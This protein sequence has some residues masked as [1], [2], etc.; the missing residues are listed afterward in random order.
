MHA[1][2][3]AAPLALAFTSAACLLAACASSRPAPPKAPAEAAEEPTSPGDQFGF[4]G[5][6]VIARMR[7]AKVSGSTVWLGH[8]TRTL[9]PVH[10][11]IVTSLL[12]AATGAPGAG[13]VDDELP[14]GDPLLALDGLAVNVLDESFEVMCEGRLSRP[15]LRYAGFVSSDDGPDLPAALL[16]GGAPTLLATL[17]APCSGAYVSGG[18]ATAIRAAD[19]RS[20]AIPEAA[21]E[22]LK[23]WE[24]DAQ[25]GSITQLVAG[26]SGFV[27]VQVDTPDRCDRSEDHHWY[28]HRATRGPTGWTFEPLAD[29]NGSD[30]FDRVVDV[31]GDGVLDALTQ[32]GAFAGKGYQEWEPDLRLFWP[33]GLGCDGHD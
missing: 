6:E 12:E 21:L 9:A 3:S 22:E 29:G 7:L 27:H 11:T 26:D 19:A 32:R 4:D 28:L 14:P 30:G 20:D 33:P 2:R 23:V 8:S 5:A 18:R 31:D 16:A 25:E 13:I 24:R 10:P 17:I 15:R 1:L